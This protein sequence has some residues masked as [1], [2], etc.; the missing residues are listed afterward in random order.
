MNIVINIGHGGKDPGAINAVQNVTE[1]EFN[2]GLGNA[3]HAKLIKAGH[4]VDTVI[5]DNR[6]VGIVAKMAN[7][8][9]P[10]IVVSLHSNASPN[11]SA[12]GTET[13]YW[14]TS[15]K[16][17]TL[18]ACIQPHMVKVLGLPDRGC[19][20]RDNL[21]VLRDT[22]CPAV[23]VEPFFISTTK[24]YLVAAQKVDELAQAIADGIEDYFLRQVTP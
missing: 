15:S 1:H 8:L 6:G 11:L 17:K 21:A 24:D 16:G 19:K 9:N 13:L 12:T 23:I 4:R 14:H 20:S 2:K 22:K 18:A 7:A 3:L 10:D 5:Q